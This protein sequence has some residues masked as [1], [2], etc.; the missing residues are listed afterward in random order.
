MKS[1]AAFAP[2][3]LFVSVDAWATREGLVPSNGPYEMTKQHEIERR[4]R[5]WAATS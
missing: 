3:L 4:N 2:L 1:K 5:T